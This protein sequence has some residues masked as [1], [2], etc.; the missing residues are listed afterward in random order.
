MQEELLIKIKLDFI[1]CDMKMAT[2]R[3]FTKYSENQ[4][5][6]PAGNPDGGQWT[7][8]GGGG[9][10][11]TSKP[12]PLARFS[13]NSNKPKVFVHSNKKVSIV[14]EDGIIETRMNGSKSWRNNN[15]GNIR[16]GKVANNL[17]A[18]GNNNGFAVFQN[19]KTG[20]NA[21]SAILKKPAYSKL[22]VDEAVSRWAPSVENDVSSNQRNIR[23]IGNFTGKEK[24][25]ELSQN[26]LEQLVNAI[27]KNEGWVQGTIIEE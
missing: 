10:G 27:E 1:I 22:T 11:G 25:G 8:G 13:E 14:R 24:V 4:P 9:G 20:S 5:R 26:K 2:L 21:V 6:V 17:G 23:K 7:D 18:V 3:L 16:A 19:K 12:K 15:P